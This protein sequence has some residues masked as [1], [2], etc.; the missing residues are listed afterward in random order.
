MEL[1]I[2]ILLVCLLVV[3]QCFHS[4]QTHKLLN[5]AMSKNFAEYVQVEQMSKPG[6]P[7]LPSGIN[8]QLPK[9]DDVDHA[10]NLNSMFGL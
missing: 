3:Q 4:W 8:I 9:D 5:K 10:K 1:G 6:S 2:I 7:R